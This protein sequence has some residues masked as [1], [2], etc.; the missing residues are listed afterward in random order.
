MNFAALK[1]LPEIFACENNLYATHMPIRECRSSKP[2]WELE[3]CWII[4]WNTNHLLKIE[5]IQE[6]FDKEFNGKARKYGS[7]LERFRGQGKKG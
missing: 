1:R 5:F 7:R 2:A 4:S 3:K 6:W